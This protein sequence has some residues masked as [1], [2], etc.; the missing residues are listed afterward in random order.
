M[1]F[2][3][4][5]T[6]FKKDNSLESVFCNDNGDLHKT[7]ITLF[8]HYNNIEKVK[9]LISMGPVYHLEKDIDLPPNQYHGS[10]PIGAIGGVSIFYERDNIASS[11]D[12]NKRYFSNINEWS[13]S[14]WFEPYDYVFNEKNNQW[15]TLC[16][17][18]PRKLRKMSTLL[19]HSNKLAPDLKDLVRQEVEV[20]QILKE[21]EI[22]KNSVPYPPSSSHLPASFHLNQSSLAK[23]Q[24]SSSFGLPPHS[25]LKI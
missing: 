6:I 22:L 12:K 8:L 4:Y 5:I 20:R 18:I 1:A 17:P 10:T 16:G 25:I 15:Y 23:N 13:N 2:S 7:G 11:L 19:L 3:S 21:E 24:H 14:L 9:K